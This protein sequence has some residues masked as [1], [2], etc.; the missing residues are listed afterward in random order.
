MDATQPAQAGAGQRAPAL[1]RLH[2]LPGVQGQLRARPRAGRRFQKIEIAEPSVEDTVEIL[3]GLKSRYEEHHKVAYTD[4]AL[5]A[6]RRA[7]RPSTSTTASCRTRP[8]T[9]STRPVP[10]IACVRRRTAPT[11]STSP[12]WRRWW[13]RWRASRPRPSPPARPRAA[14]AR[15]RTSSR[16]SS[17]DRTRPSRSSPRR[18]SWR[19]RAWAAPEKPIGSFLFSRPHRRGQDGAG[20]AARARAGRG[21]PALRHERVLGEA[22]GLA[23]SSA[24][25]R[26][27]WAS[28]RAAC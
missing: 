20:Q 6:S 5:Q 17:S 19:A 24:R 12:R 8:S 9:S 11:R 2:D 10:R 14:R 26:A 16:R 15:S 22:H 4:A 1:H 3:H 25:L 18:S 13:R 27:T 28:T 21:V 23:G 7:R